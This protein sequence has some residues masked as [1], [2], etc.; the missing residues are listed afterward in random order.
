MLLLHNKQV[1]LERQAVKEETL[2]SKE[3]VKNI[4]KLTS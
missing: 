4:I 1:S 2:K 3:I